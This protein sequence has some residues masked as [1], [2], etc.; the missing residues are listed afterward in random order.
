LRGAARLVLLRAH[1][2]DHAEIVVGELQVVL[3]LHPVAVERRVVRQLAVLLEHLRSVARARLSIRLP[4]LPAALAAT[5][6]PS[7][8]RR[9]LL[10]RFWF[11]GN[12]FP[13]L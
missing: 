3:G 8:Q 2:G 9:R 5:I 1:V 11:K 13:C 10:L 7:G 12:P 6:V 4:W